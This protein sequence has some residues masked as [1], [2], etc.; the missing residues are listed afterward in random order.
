MGRAL[1]PEQW[2]AVARVWTNEEAEE[3]AVG[4]EAFPPAINPQ[5]P[6]KA[7]VKGHRPA[8]AEPWTRWTVH[9]SLLICMHQLSHSPLRGH[10][11]PSL[12]GL[13]GFRLCPV[14][15]YPKLGSFTPPKSNMAARKKIKSCTCCVCEPKLLPLKQGIHMKSGAGASRLGE[16]E[17]SGLSATR[18]VKKERWRYRHRRLGTVVEVVARSPV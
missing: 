13:R 8:D 12:K 14:W 7:T 16:G 10:L 6:A 1:P 4:R 18:R 9:A 5:N 15:N 2:Q 17:V 11:S 3:G